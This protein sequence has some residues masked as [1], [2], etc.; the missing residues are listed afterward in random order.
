MIPRPVLAPALLLCLVL[1]LAACG[2]G[3]DDGVVPSPTPTAA[4]AP[5]TADVAPLVDSL[6]VH[7]GD[8]VP[9]EPFDMPYGVDVGPDGRVYVLNAGNDRVVV[10]D[11]LEEVASWDGTA[12][13]D[14]PI[15]TLGFG[16]LAVGGDG[17]VVV[18]DNAAPRVRAFDRDGEALHTFAPVTDGQP[19]LARPIG[20]GVAGDEV[21][22]TDDE[23]G[24]VLVWAAD[25]TFLRRFGGPGDDGLVHPTGLAVLAD[26]SVVV[27]DYEA[28]VVRRYAPDGGLNGTWREPGPAGSATVPEGLAVDVD[29]TVLVTEYETGGISLLPAEP[30]EG[31]WISALPEPP[32]AEAVLSAPTDLAIAPDGTVYVVDQRQARVAVFTREPRP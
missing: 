19:P 4:M 15:E 12:S 21:W 8:L 6:L 11:G 20:V 5:T 1:G 2:G 23:T 31:E 17:T 26:G 28:E 10:F 30:G 27:A 3:G 32:P 7:V 18:V 13:P 9:D 25:G 16:G 22:V 14:G 29:G 24:F